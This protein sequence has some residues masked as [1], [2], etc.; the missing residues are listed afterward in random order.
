[1]I[2]PVSVAVIFMLLL[3]SLF[4]SIDNAHASFLSF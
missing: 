4:V 3:S 2:S 1:M